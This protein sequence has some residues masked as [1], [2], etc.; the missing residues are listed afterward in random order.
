M[1]STQNSRLTCILF[2][3]PCCHRVLW[4]CTARFIDHDV[5]LA[6]LAVF[7]MGMAGVWAPYSL[8]FFRR[9]LSVVMQDWG[10][11]DNPHR[12]TQWSI[13]FNPQKGLRKGSEVI[14]LAGLHRFRTAEVVKPDHKVDGVPHVRVDLKYQSQG[15]EGHLEKTYRRSQVAMTNAELKA[16][17]KCNDRWTAAFHLLFGTVCSSVMIAGTAFFVLW[18]VQA[19]S[20]PVCYDCCISDPPE[21]SMVLNGSALSNCTVTRP[22]PAPGEYCLREVEGG[23]LE[24]GCGVQC[25]NM[26]ECFYSSGATIGTD[27]WVWVAVQGI[28]LGILLDM[29]LTAFFAWAAS[30]AV[31]RKN[32]KW[33]I[34]YEDAIVRTQFIFVWLGYFAWFLLLGLVYIPFGE[35]IQQYL[36]QSFPALK[37]VKLLPSIIRMDEAFVCP[38]I[39]TQLVSL[40]MD[41]FVPYVLRTCILRPLAATADAAAQL[42]QDAAKFAAKEVEEAAKFAAKEVEG[43]AKFA[44]KEVEEVAKFAAKEVVGFAKKIADRDAEDPEPLATE[45]QDSFKHQMNPGTATETEACSSS[46]LLAQ[47]QPCLGDKIKSE[48]WMEEFM[49][50]G[51]WKEVELV[52]G[53]CSAEAVSHDDLA[54][55]LIAE[56]QLSVVNLMP[57]YRKMVI[58]FCYVTMFSVAWPF[59]PFLAL[60]NNF[61]EIKLDAVSMFINHRRPLPGQPFA[62]RPIGAWRECLELQVYLGV[63]F[64]ALGVCMSTGELEVWMWTLGLLPRQCRPSKGEMMPWPVYCS[65]FVPHCHLVCATSMQPPACSTDTEISLKIFVCVRF[66]R[67][68][69]SQEHEDCLTFSQRCLAALVI[70]HVVFIAVW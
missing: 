26:V 49:K 48:E 61:I 55:A 13:H 37:D 1:K 56:S 60:V 16:T 17:S 64:S 58:Q 40:V 36:T 28:T 66:I 68:P 7:G 12:G 25:N 69:P 35:Q 27:R 24:Y 23:A 4:W 44:A 42:A 47:K 59:C 31:Q 63:V 18:Y 15:S 22:F 43:V 67:P 21:Q 62:D 20:L 50:D 33:R 3:F 51:A 65:A 32:W 34:D 6:G 11:G 39:V 70:S 53:L 57:D 54:D 46:Q 30:K 38:L 41:T 14:V 10:F 19:K 52:S 2:V 9:R 29:V 45:T 5:Y 8:A